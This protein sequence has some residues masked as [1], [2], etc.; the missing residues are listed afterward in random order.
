MTWTSA[1][2]NT[3]SFNTLKMDYTSTFSIAG[4]GADLMWDVY[5]TAWIDVMSGGFAMTSL[6]TFNDG[7]EALDVN[8]EVR[9]VGDMFYITFDGGETWQ[10]G[11]TEEITGTF[12]EALPKAR[13]ST[14][15]M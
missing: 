11:K 10:G 8:M 3:A 12:A 2:A 5:G 7:T 4:I 1:F 6:G 15:M 14:R 9:V 13:A